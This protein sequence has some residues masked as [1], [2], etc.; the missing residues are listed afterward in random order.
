MLK[1]DVIAKQKREETRKKIRQYE[2]YIKEH[3]LNVIRA[4]SV[5]LDRINPYHVSKIE[6]LQ[7]V[8]KHDYSKWD[9]EE[10]DAYRQFYYPT[11]FENPDPEK[12]DRAWERHYTLNDHH[13]E[14]WYNS[15]RGPSEMSNEAMLEMISDWVAMSIKFHNSPYEWFHGA[16]DSGEIVL[17][18]KTIEKCEVILSNKVIK[19][20]TF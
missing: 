1:I 11:T 20:S 6:M 19:K 17:H 14:F 8:F 9:R 16:L 12:L 10:F 15:D 13:P 4:Y 2:E 7:R 3:R 5:F 18:P